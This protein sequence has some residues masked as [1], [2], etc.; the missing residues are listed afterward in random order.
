MKLK[1]LLNRQEEA[2]PG[3]WSL[4]DLW[5]QMGR[6]LFSRNEGVPILGRILVLV[7]VLVLVL[8]LVICK[9]SLETGCII[10]VG[11]HGFVDSRRLCGAWRHS[12]GDLN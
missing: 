8:A 1:S 12:P 9:S 3:G 7:L 10:D 4:A 6:L 5:E 2:S 11:Q